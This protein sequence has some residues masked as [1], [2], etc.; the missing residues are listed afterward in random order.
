MASKVDSPVSAF[1]DHS[2]LTLSDTLSLDQPEPFSSTFF[3]RNSHIAAARTI[4]LKTFL[5]GSV[6]ALFTVFFIL[7]VYWAALGKSTS[8]NLAGWI[9]VSTVFFSLNS[10]AIFSE[11]FSSSFLVQWSTRDLPTNSPFTVILIPGLRQLPHRSERLTCLGRSK[12]QNLMDNRPCNQLPKRCRGSRKRSHRGAVLGRHR[13]CVHFF[14]YPIYCLY[15]RIQSTPALRIDYT[16]QPPLRTR[17]MTRRPLLRC[18]LP[19]LG[20]R[21]PS[22]HHPTPSLT[23]S[24]TQSAQPNPP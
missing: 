16:M 23:S 22:A 24:L 10:D 20:M 6:L 12:W 18:L 15:I 13:Q 8:H 2:F 17:R 1:D 4:Y 11:L 21:M 19:R 3:S 9:V 5:T 7:S 14:S